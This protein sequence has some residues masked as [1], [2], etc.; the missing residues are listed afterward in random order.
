MAATWIKALHVSKSKA[1]TTKSK[2]SVIASVIDYVENPQ[3]TDGGR[4]ITS[5]E[6]DS[7]I[8]D[9]EFTLAKREYEYITGRNQ[10]R[11]DVL[12]YHIRQSFKPGETTPEEANEIGRQLVL[13]FTKGKH[14]FVVATHIDKQHIHNHIIF[15]SIALNCERK[16]VDFKRS[17]KAIRRISDLLCAEHGLS[18]IQNPQPSKG[19]NYGKWLGDKKPPTHKQILQRSIDDIIPNCDTYDD[20]IARLIASGFEVSSKRKHVTAKL[21]D[22]GKPTRLNSLGDE[23]TIA[24]IRARLGMV[25]TIASGGDGGTRNAPSLLIDIQA[26][27]RDGKGA[28]YRQWAA[29]FNLK[30]SAKTLLFL[31]DSGIDSYE[32]LVKK[33]A[34]AS[35]E[36]AALTARI[37]EIETRLKDVAELQKQIGT[38]GKTRDVFAKYKASKWSRKFYDDHATDV[39]LHRAAKKYFDGLGMKK[40]PS[41]NSL[42]QEYATLA[43]EKKKLYGGYH[44]IKDTS[45]E[46]SV[47]R[48]NAERLLGVSPT[49]Q[50]RDVSRADTQHN[51]R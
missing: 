48:A 21:P 13:S 6:C 31:Q 49:A 12:A 11:R 15:N 43:A 1:N 2:A 45:R 22:W 38:Y 51:S 40:L 9:E 3:K 39:I 41:I 16:F 25:K 37:K 10:G 7:R 14:A 47:A 27:L 36:F 50:N 34:S 29:I 18:V 33:S 5:Y 28:G 26:K 32:D 20:F 8:A 17:G 19:R 30:Q 42:R 35:G 24:A 4:L 46:L 44:K 23:Y